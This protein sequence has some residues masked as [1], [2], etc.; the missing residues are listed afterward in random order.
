M[1]GGFLV[2]VC[3]QGKQRQVRWYA[4]QI[5]KFLVAFLRI[6][7]DAPDQLHMSS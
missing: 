1:P 2:R 3:V 5:H 4:Q 7:D 6:K